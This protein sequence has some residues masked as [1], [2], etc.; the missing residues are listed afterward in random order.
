MIARRLAVCALSLWACG[1][2]A[3]ELPARAAKA[4]PQADKARQC[5]IDGQRGFETLGG[6]CIRISGYVSVGVGGSVRH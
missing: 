4:K 3:A 5:E 6:G 1:A 2:A